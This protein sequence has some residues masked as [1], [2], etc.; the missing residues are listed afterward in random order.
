MLKSIIFIFSLFF[1]PVIPLSH[2][3]G[4]LS[5]DSVYQLPSHWRDQNNAPLELA[6]LVGKIQVVA[7]IYTY[8]EHSCPVILSTLKRID[9]KL[10]G[11]QKQ[12]LNFLLISL[13][14]DRDTP[15]ILNAYMNKNN[16]AQTRW[17]LLHGNADDVLELAALFGV[18]Y[19]P[20][21]ANNDIAHSNMITILDRQGV[22]DYQMQGISDDL[23]ES[24]A[25][26]NA[27]TQQ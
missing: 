23:S 18:R 9:K 6:D 5:D 20:M 19:K 24:L 15:D 2:A 8:C 17:R 3:G 16:L 13:D 14:P 10:S 25:A 27:L 11:E 4:L 26:I 22:I 12:Q 21:D 1:F 7:F